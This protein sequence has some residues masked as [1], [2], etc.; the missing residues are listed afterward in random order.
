MIEK[1][2]EML[3]AY[4]PNS[5]EELTTE[6]VDR[7]IEDCLA[8][9]DHNLELLGEEYPT[10]ATFSNEYKIMDNTVWTNGFWTGMLWLAYEF[11]GEEKYKEAAEKNVRSFIHRID[12]LIEVNHHDLGFLYTPSCVSA[13]KLTG[14]LEARDA[15][16]KAAK[17][18]ASRYQKTGKFIQAWGELG[19][20]DNYRLIVDC[21]LNI[22]LL[23]WASEET[24]NEEFAEM[25]KEHFYT[26]VKN[27]I[28]NDASAFHTFYFDPETGEPAYGKTRQGYSDDSAWAR[29]Q[30]RLIYGIALCN[31]YYPVDTNIEY[32]QA[33]TN[34]FLNR[35]PENFV[36]YWDLIF[37]DTSGQPRDTSAAA[38]AVC[39]INQMAIEIPNNEN[40]REYEAWADRI[41]YNLI[42]HYTEQKAEG[43]IALL[44]EG[45]Y[46]WHSGKGVNEGNIWGDYFYLE[47]LMRKK[48][49]WKMYW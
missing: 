24:G 40:L 12:N 27:A 18:L 23:F 35:L 37:D 7:A 19:A 28:R 34:Y 10:P 15:A 33:V 3:K 11:T 38:I 8:K 4:M 16:I 21:L 9:I 14:N 43:V 36:C 42:T 29:G 2:I 22:P 1:N 6:L 45:V 48:N 26:T 20:R 32:F 39:G 30:A 41:L 31:A 5:A 25:A 44:N 13:Y 17:Q 47:A 46:S 49:N